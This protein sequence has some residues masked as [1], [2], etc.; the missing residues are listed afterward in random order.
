MTSPPE[1]PLSF[2]QELVPHLFKAISG[3]WSCA[4]VG[5]PGSGLS[6]LL[7]FMVEPRVAR[8]YLGDEA[9]QNLL[10][11]LEADRLLEAAAFYPRLAAEVVAA[12]HAQDWL[13]GEQAALRR[14]S[15]APEGGPAVAPNHRD[16]AEPL[17][18]LL[19]HI[20]GEL[21]RRV[22][23]VC[24]EF[25]A[26]LAGWP[27]SVLRELRALR[28]AHKYRL[29]FVAGAPRDPAW[30]AADNPRDPLVAGPEKLAELFAQHTFPLRPYSN[31][32]TRAAIARK[33]VGWA[34]PPSDEQQDQLHRLTGGHARLLIDSLVQLEPRLHLPWA[35]IERGLL[36]DAGLAEVCRVVWQALEPGD[37]RAL[38]LLAHDQREALPEAG[39]RRLQLFGLAA[40]GPAFVFSAIME[41]FVLA[42]PEP[43]EAPA[44]VSQLR[45]PAAAVLW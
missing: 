15:A 42:Q 2:R 40:G 38:W 14:L 34:Q 16:S 17:A 41:S 29:A 6:N 4:V 19:H 37:R 27:V 9:G 8:H 28:D 1:L 23:F 39:L 18:R 44:R 45:D 7:R 24:D 3:G 26:A 13:R 33:T 21:Q 20:C 32:D 43:P 12:A 10:V 5:L 22:V 11:Y 31:A 30:L 35:N 25:G 36:A